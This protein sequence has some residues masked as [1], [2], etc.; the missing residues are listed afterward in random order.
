MK[1]ILFIFSLFFCSICIGQETLSKETAKIIIDIYMNG[2]QSGDT[3]KMKSVMH[4]NIRME[5]AFVN[6][7]QENLVLYIDPDALLKHVAVSTKE[8]NWTVETKDYIV[9]SD[10]NLAHV[11]APYYFYINDQFVRCGV[12]SF[13]LVFTDESWKIS[14]IVESRRIGGCNPK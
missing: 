12:N 13:T 1:S 6:E 4:R 9:N 7:K 8:N 11:W 5:T 10:G 14:S 3:L 2:Y